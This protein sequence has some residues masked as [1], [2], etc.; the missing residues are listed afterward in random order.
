M[1]AGGCSTFKHAGSE[2]SLLA[3][4]PKPATKQGVLLDSAAEVA[5]EAPPAAEAAKDGE[6]GWPPELALWVERA[7]GQCTSDEARAT[8]AALRAP[9]PRSSPILPPTPATAPVSKRRALPRAP[10]PAV[11]PQRSAP[12]DLRAISPVIATQERSN[13]DNALKN[14]IAAATSSGRLWKINWKKEPVPDPTVNPAAR[15]RRPKPQTFGGGDE[16]GSSPRPKELESEAED[17]ELS[18]AEK[19][20][21][22]LA[23]LEDKMI[24]KTSGFINIRTGIEETKDGPLPSVKD[25]PKPVRAKT[26]TTELTAEE[27][28]AQL[29]DKMIKKTSGVAS[30]KTTSA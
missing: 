22:E 21:E 18:A 7:F 14:K 12:F 8:V 29:E 11:G 16:E 3:P 6:D 19:A 27:K 10:R 4:K 20:A 30:L 1:K 15:R 17:E 23:R 5:K 26:P 25:L 2:A 9:P 28:L 13:I 24:K